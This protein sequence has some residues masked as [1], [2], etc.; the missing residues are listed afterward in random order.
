[1]T[2]NFD[3]KIQEKVE[4]LEREN[5]EMRKDI[6]IVARS[7]EKLD[8]VIE[9]IKKLAENTSKIIAIHD[10]KHRV[11]EKQFFKKENDILEVHKRINSIEH[12]ILEKLTQTTQEFNSKLDKLET[13]KW[14]FLGGAG[15]LVFLITLASNILPKIL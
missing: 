7:T 15:V 1:M 14:M 9:Q 3:N 5:Y 6:Q 12:Q 4:N 11:H 2:E 13:S 8:E 10:E